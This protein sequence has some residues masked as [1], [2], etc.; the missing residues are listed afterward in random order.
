MHGPHRVELGRLPLLGEERDQRVGLLIGEVERRHADIEPRPDLHHRRILQEVEEPR[1]LRAAAFRRQIGRKEVRVG[2]RRG[3]GPSLPVDDVT[4]AAVVLRHPLAPFFHQTGSRIQ[5]RHLFGRDQILGQAENHHGDAAGL[6]LREVEVR[7]LELVAVGLRPLV[8]VDARV[9]HL[10][11]DPRRHVVLDMLV[12]SVLSRDVVVHE[13]EIE[14]VERF[15]SLDGELGSDR[16]QP[17]ESFD[18]VTGIAAVLFD[19]SLAEKDELVV[20]G[21]GAQLRFRVAIA[22]RV[23][24][25]PLG[26]IV[27][28][29]GIGRA[30]G[31]CHELRLLQGQQKRGDVG[32]LLIGE[33]QRRH[34][35]VGVVVLRILHPV[36]DPRRVRLGA[37]AGEVESV[38]ALQRIVIA[39]GQP[40]LAALLVLQ[41]FA[42]D[43]AG[44]ATHALHELLAPSRIAGARRRLPRAMARLAEEIGDQGVDLGILVPD[45]LLSLR[46]GHHARIDHVALIEEGRHPGR[47]AEIVRLGDPAE[48]PLRRRLLGDAVEIGS[49][50]A[51]IGEAPVVDLVA[52]VAAVQLDRRRR[53]VDL[54]ALVDPRLAGVTLDAS[55]LVVLARIHRRLVEGILFPRP[56]ALVVVPRSGQQGGDR[57]RPAAL[58]ARAGRNVTGAAEFRGPILSAVARGAT[59]VQQGMR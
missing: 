1:R 39:S 9:A 46:S 36:V 30:D 16:L 31:R 52:G 21:H 27:H 42:V 34:R 7:H 8:V 43:V 28:C 32:R 49:R 24:E 13:P 23:D 50:P 51:E 14:E 57:A 47:G 33:P 59:E 26:Q 44:H 18:V 5:R 55:R 41:P 3:D 25:V 29:C 11:V 20:Q 35:R 10:V 37:D 40:V 53:L 45:V 15:R 58:H 56:V 54:I 48:R 38:V 12:F 6:I 22:Q 2:D 17:L 4:S 19:R